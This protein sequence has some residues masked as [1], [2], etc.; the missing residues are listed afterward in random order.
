MMA[1]A[2]PC[3]AQR[4]QAAKPKTAAAADSESAGSG[5]KALEQRVNTYYEDIV[6]NQRASA[7]DL[8]APESR[9]AYYDTDYN[10]TVA[11]RIK[12]IDMGKDGATAQVSVVRSR[13]VPPFQGV[14]DFTS[15]DTWKLEGGQWRIVLPSAGETPAAD[16]QTLTP[17]EVKARMQA[18]EKNVNT[19]AY[20]TALE[21]AMAAQKKKEKKAGSK[22]AAPKKLDS[23]K[24]SDPNHPE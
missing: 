5:R 15:V 2:A 24:K 16:K 4:T 7:I 23:D 12:G 11:Y 8:V 19:R 20:L 21:K 1:L 10:G 9:K 22:K 14:M 6:K 17:E 3:G 13:K 18:A